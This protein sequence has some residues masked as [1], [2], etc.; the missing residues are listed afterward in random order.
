MSDDLLNYAAQL[1]DEER[2]NSD[3]IFNY[4]LWVKNTVK[5]DSANYSE[6]LDAYKTNLTKTLKTKRTYKHFV[7]W[8]S[9]SILFLSFVATC[10]FLYI[11]RNDLKHFAVAFSTLGSLAT[12]YLTIPKIISNYLF[13]K[14]EEKYMCEIVKNIQKH[15]IALLHPTIDGNDN[16]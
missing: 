6:I 9:L 16:G 3:Y 14:D 2:V 7:F 13:N 8:V 1:G 5:E 10:I 4:G 12:I 15:D 11:M